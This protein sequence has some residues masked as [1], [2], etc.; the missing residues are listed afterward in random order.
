MLTRLR[1][2]NFKTF[3]NSEI[4]LTRRHLLIGKNNSGKTNLCLALRFLGATALVNYEEAIGA[5]PGGVDGFCHWGL[6]PAKSESQTAEF[7]C[8]YQ[9]PYNGEVLHYEYQLNLRLAK[10][11]LPPSSGQPNIQTAR[12]R[13]AVSGARWADVVL[14]ESDGTSSRVLDDSR[15]IGGGSDR[16]YEELRPPLGASLLAKTYEK[17]TN[18]LLTHFKRALGSIFFFAPSPPLM[19]YGWRL[20]DQPQ[21]LAVRE[22]L[23]PYGNNLPLVL[24]QI[25]NEDEP[26]YRGI[27]EFLRSVEPDLDSINFFVTPDNRPVPYLIMKGGRRASWDTLSDGSL[28]ILALSAI[29]AQAERLDDRPD[30]PSVLCIIEE[31]ENR[32]YRGLLPS[33]WEKLASFAPR[34]QFLFTS[35][36]PYFI[37]LFERDL[38]S[39]T[40]LKREG[41]ITTARSLAEYRQ[42]FEHEREVSDASLGEQHFREIFE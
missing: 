20:F 2:H 36:S 21:S 31:P 12:E 15:L 28:C 34:G 17:D 7:G 8:S 11:S 33:L 19:R 23:D 22:G 13:L 37:D 38:S 18:R 9:L 26:R 16:G 6:D 30:W 35:H 4:E 10:H 39:V 41:G 25:K 24:F 1:L 29:F 5:V 42:R 14:L 32:L 40:R 27:I 3:V